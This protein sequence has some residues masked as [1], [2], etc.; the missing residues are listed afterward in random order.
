MIGR[1]THL[2]DIRKLRELLNKL[3]LGDPQGVA[4]L[5]ARWLQYVDWWDSRATKAKSR[6]LGLR[7]TVVVGGALIPALVGLRE[8]AALAPYAAWFSV[9]SIV[10]SL[11]IAICAGL[12]SLFGYG[13]IWREKRIA[14]EIIKSEGFS[15][16]EL[17]GKYAAFK[18]HKEAYHAFAAHVEELILKEIKEYIVAISPKPGDKE[19]PAEKQ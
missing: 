11:L 13:D 6:Y 12:D 18:T 3:E 2:V 16:F 5:E 17:T 1:A 4:F 8:M 9:A 14:A 15:F 10:V 19:S 7:S